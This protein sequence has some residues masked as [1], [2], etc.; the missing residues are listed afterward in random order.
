MSRLQGRKTM[1]LLERLKLFLATLALFPMKLL[2][3]RLLSNKRGITGLVIATIIALVTI[4]IIVPIGI[5]ITYN[6]Q[7]TITGMGMTA[8]SAAANASTAVFN[9][10]WQAYNLASILSIVAAAGAIITIIVASFSFY[11]GRKGQ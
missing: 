8:N 3:K 4:S 5:I 6:I 2:P 9:N 7:T 11:Q 10:A 1:K